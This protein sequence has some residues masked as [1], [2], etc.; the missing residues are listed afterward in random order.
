[1]VTKLSEGLQ[2]CCCAVIPQWPPLHVDPGGHTY[3]YILLH[4]GFLT[5]KTRGHHHFVR[6]GGSEQNAVHQGNELHSVLR[7]LETR[8]LQENTL[9]DKV[10]DVVC[11]HAILARHCR[12]WQLCTC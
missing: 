1:M 6:P 10:G 3:I 5:S 11:G 4:L 2:L 8:L 9:F 12:R 7:V